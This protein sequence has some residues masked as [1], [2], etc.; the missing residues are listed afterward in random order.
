[1]SA[2]SVNPEI[3]SKQSDVPVHRVHGSEVSY[4]TYPA[5]S[6]SSSSVQWSVIP[7][8]MQT[9]MS[10]CIQVKYPLQIVY[11]STVT[12]T[13]LIPEPNYDSL[14]N[15]ADMRLLLN[16]NININGQ[17]L[18]SQQVHD[19]LPDLVAHY[20]RE[21]RRKHPLGAI[22]TTQ[23]LFDGV[24][25][26]GGP[27]GDYNDSEMFEGGMKRGAYTFSGITRATDSAT[28]T[29]DLIGWLYVP[30]LLGLD[31]DDD[32]GLI[33]IRNFDVST[34]LDL[35]GKNIVTHAIGAA[36]TIP[37]APTVTITSAP[38]MMVKFTSVPQDLLPVGPLVYDHL[39][40]ERFPTAYG[41]L[42]INTSATITGNNIQ[43]PN[44]PRFVFLFVR[45]S[46]ANKAH[47]DSDTFAA[48]TNVSVNFNNK[49]GLLASASQFDLW[50]MSKECGLIDSYPQFVGL[51]Q[52]GFTQIGTVGSLVCL[53][54]GKHISLGDGVEVGQAG[55]FNFN[56]QV[57]C[58]N[59]NQDV[60]Y[61]P[62]TNAT[63][64]CVV[65]Y[66]QSLVIDD[67][68]MISLETPL[69]RGIQGDVAVV[70]YSNSFD[71]AVAVGGSIGSF[72]KKVWNFIKGHKVIS[73]VANALAPALS[74][75]PKVGPIAG[76]LA[77][78][79]GQV[80]THL[81]VGTGGQMMSKADLKKAIQRL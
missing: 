44:V 78:T 24:G 4:R 76:P 5:S 3:D 34:T 81:G 47:Y 79:V 58:K 65:A 22:D 7:P 11:A 15:C 20:K 2:V 53:A 8:S 66:D 10:R 42:A 63:L 77:S 57:T 21:Y 12:G 49:T 50:H 26:S 35:S 54:F 38:T 72:F 61:G 71:G 18:P 27:M 14:R 73:G 9:F 39:R 62:L 25:T 75:I 60:T 31:Q 23:F 56:V 36:K 69:A 37:T 52:N 64:Y 68:G 1:M 28:L 30:E 55:A 48:I 33:R 67:G 59:V 40:I 16:Q 80:A 70:P 51:S 74:M 46:D 6:Y 17:S 41:S 13:D 29:V 45:E 43:L 19:C 32:L